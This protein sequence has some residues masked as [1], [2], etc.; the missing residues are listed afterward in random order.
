MLNQFLRAAVQKNN[1]HRSIN[2]IVRSTLN[3]EQDHKRWDARREL[4]HAEIGRLKPDMIAFNKACIP[5][6]SAR[7]LRDAATALTGID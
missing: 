5:L 3:L 1:R 7:G 4:I 2:P 6:Q